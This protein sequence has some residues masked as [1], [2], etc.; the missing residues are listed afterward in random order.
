MNKQLSSILI[1]VTVL[2]SAP[3]VHGAVYKWQ[4]EQ[5]ITHFSDAPPAGGR[6]EIV[7]QPRLPPADPEAERRLEELLQ[8]QK[9]EEEAR[10]KKKREKMK[11]AAEQAARMETCRRAKK[12]LVVLE[13]RPG[14]RIKITEPDGTLRRLTEEERQTRLVVVQKQIADSCEE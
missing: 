8:S 4:D 10:Q 12:R 1:A 11:A 5:G 3:L 14:S 9:Q 2:L 7:P 13:S 6:V